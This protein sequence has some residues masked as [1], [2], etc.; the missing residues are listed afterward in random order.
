M[1]RAMVICAM[2]LVTLV[3]CTSPRERLYTLQGPVSLGAEVS[4]GA[5]HRATVFLGPVSIP[6]EVDR[7]QL[8]ERGGAYHVT[9]TE[10]D[11]WAVPLR[12]ALPRLLAEE[13]TRKSHDRRFV[14]PSSGAIATPSARL[15][16]DIQRF[17]GSR[18]DGVVVRAHWVYRSTVADSVPVEGDAEAHAAI[19]E[20]GYEGFVD[21]LRRAST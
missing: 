18:S 10:Q 1:I 5:E 12:E 19:S 2:S 17:E 3:A 7:P 11:R 14:P 21:A 16:V 20:R 15:A 6:A 8:V 9:L 4:G 13:L